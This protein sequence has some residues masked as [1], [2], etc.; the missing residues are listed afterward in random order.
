MAFTQAQLNAVLAAPEQ[1]IAF[2]NDSTGNYTDV[3]VQNFNTD[4]TKKAGWTQCAQTLTAA[5]ALAAIK[6]N[7]S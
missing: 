4:T 6:A 7:L 5:Q 3:Y 2:V 1:V